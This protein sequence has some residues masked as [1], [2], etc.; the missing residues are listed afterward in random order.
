MIY[1]RCWLFLASLFPKFSLLFH[2]IIF[3]YFY[4][5]HSL[6]F[7]E[8]LNKHSLFPPN[9]HQSKS[10]NVRIITELC[11]VQHAYHCHLIL[12][13]LT[14]YANLSWHYK[15]PLYEKQV[16]SPAKTLKVQ[17]CAVKNRTF[18]F[19]KKMNSLLKLTGVWQIVPRDHPVHS[20]GILKVRT[21]S[22]W[23]FLERILASLDLYDV[24][25][26]LVCWTT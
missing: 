15:L 13:F 19:R 21:V 9:T 5:C 20:F 23:K 10:T 2:L 22:I 26:K 6:I 18:A 11:K 4:M 1:S 8:I 14:S 12:K 7:T 16:M 24:Q 17:L 3:V 25:R